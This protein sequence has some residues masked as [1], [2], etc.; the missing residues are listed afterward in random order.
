M[1][2]TV[3]IVSLCRSDSN[4]KNVPPAGLCGLLSWE[5]PQHLMVLILME[6]SL[7]LNI[8][9]FLFKKR[10]LCMIQTTY[11]VYS[12]SKPTSRAL[13]KLCLCISWYLSPSPAWPQ[14]SCTPS[15]EENLTLTSKVCTREQRL[16]KHVDL[17]LVLTLC[18]WPLCVL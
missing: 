15:C 9:C 8:S 13:N 5:P 2:A 10:H 16:K 3:F 6:A 1:G 14:H 12:F 17:L 4:V 11:G 18:S 7:N